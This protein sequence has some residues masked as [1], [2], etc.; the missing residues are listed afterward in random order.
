MSGTVHHYKITSE[1][2]LLVCCSLGGQMVREQNWHLSRC[3]N[4]AVNGL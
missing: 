2:V 3:D 4:Q 1:S